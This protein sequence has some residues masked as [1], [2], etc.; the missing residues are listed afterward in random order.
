MRALVTG[1]AGLVGS[2]IID[3]LLETTKV[4]VVSVDNYVSGNSENLEKARSFSNFTELRGDITDEIFLATV[5][6]EGYDWVFHE[7]VSKN[8]VSLN[9]PVK[10][11]HTNALGTLLLLEAT[12]KTDSKKFIHASTGSVY[13]RTT[14]FPTTEITPTLPVSFYG[15]SKLAAE[16]YV[17]LFSEMFGMETTILRYFHVFGAR[18]DRSEIGGVVPHFI[19]LALSNKNIEITGDGNQVRAF[20]HV[21][22]IAK[23]NLLAAK[24]DGAAQTFNC[25]SPTRITINEL[26]HKILYLLPQSTSSLKYV[27]E[28]KGD[29][30]KFDIAT[31]R[32]HA[33]LGNIHFMD[34]DSALKKTLSEFH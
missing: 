16:N 28:R 6:S 3:L 20:T 9:N 8:T 29:I 11:L 31:E 10:D 14:E 1:G 12:R 7:A 23:I 2:E 30:Y 5:F 21:S 15:N 32:L 27:A 22:D 4:D 25:A 24:S 17:R 34:F 13:G 19:D 18:Q 26:A 33:T